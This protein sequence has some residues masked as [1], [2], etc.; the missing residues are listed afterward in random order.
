MVAGAA[1]G[2]HSTLLLVPI[3]DAVAED[4]QVL[5]PIPLGVQYF[6]Y[7]AEPPT[8]AILV[9]ILDVAAESRYWYQYSVTCG[10]LTLEH[11]PPHTPYWYQYYMTRGPLALQTYWYQYTVA[12]EPM[13]PSMSHP[14]TTYWYQTAAG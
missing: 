11:K 13:A 3:P 10:P 6:Y 9:P 14:H 8:L 4:Q 1:A 7:Q 12:C 2:W 5:V